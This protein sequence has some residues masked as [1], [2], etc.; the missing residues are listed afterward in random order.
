MNV[1]SA[2]DNNWNSAVN[3]QQVGLQVIIL[4]SS[5]GVVDT[6]TNDREPN[7]VSNVQETETADVPESESDIQ[8]QL[9]GNVQS[10]P[11]ENAPTVETT[12]ATASPGT[13]PDTCTPAS[14]TSTQTS[15]MTPYLKLVKLNIKPGDL[16]LCTSTTLECMP[17]SRHK[18]KPFYNPQQDPEAQS[19]P[20]PDLN[21]S[22]ETVIYY[23]SDI[24]DCYW[25]VDQDN[26]DPDTCKNTCKDSSN[27][28]N[29][30]KH[31]VPKRNIPK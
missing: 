8:A 31:K 18:A 25:P 15:L 7:S 9:S 3:A 1:P 2:D 27:Q 6:P 26:I 17:E 16:Q 20:N 21:S 28:C 14:S 19:I 30:Q 29:V 24:T 10:T 5:S 4:E 23:D 13:E 22:Q 11:T 12:H